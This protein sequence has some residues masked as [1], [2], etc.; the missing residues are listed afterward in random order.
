MGFEPVDP[1]N[2]EVRVGDNILKRKTKIHDSALLGHFNVIGNATID[3]DV[4][5]V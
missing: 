1:D 4:V 2:I 3:A 5:I